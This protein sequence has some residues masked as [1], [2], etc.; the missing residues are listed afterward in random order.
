MK[1]FLQVGKITNSHGINGECKVFPLTDNP[2]RFEE[3]TEVFLV[4]RD[5]VADNI[6]M[7]SSKLS[8]KSI[9]YF[10]ERPIIQFKEIQ[11]LE[12]AKKIKDHFLVI[13]RSKAIQLPKDAYFVCDLLGCVVEDSNTHYGT[14]VNIIHTG[15][16]DVYVVKNEQ[17]KEILI[18]A[19]KSVVQEVDIEEK[20][21]RIQIPEGLL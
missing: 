5:S 12:D 15:S 16:N 13:P 21:M 4:P 7:S 1:N 11:S 9:K 17:Q 8:I 20:K 2:K 14:I 3:L 6:V 18:P 19:L 10:K